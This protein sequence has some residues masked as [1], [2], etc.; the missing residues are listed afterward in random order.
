MTHVP[1]KN[2]PQSIIDVA[3]GHVQLAFAEAAATQQLIRDGRL[4]ALAVSS[5]ARFTTL[6]QVP[7]VAGALNRPGYEAVSWHALAAPSAT[8]RALM[9][10]LNAEMTRI[11]K[12]PEM[13]ERIASL[14]LIPFEPRAIEDNQRY[15][16]AETERWGTLIRKLGLAGS[17]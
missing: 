14:G 16:A 7:T 15:L 8:P 11:I 6:P 5:A 2:S 1:Y 10:R 3:A 4:R 13:Q 17:Q 12:L 9:L